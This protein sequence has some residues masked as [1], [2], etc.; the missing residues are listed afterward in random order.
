MEQLQYLI[1]RI[2]KMDE[3]YDEKLDKILYQTTKTN[4]RVTNLED[5]VAGVKN[6]VVG[7]NKIITHLQAVE[8]N[9]KGRDKTL[10]AG[11]AL[12][13]ALLTAIIQHFISKI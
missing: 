9:N 10:L 1:D 8:N 13:G 4:G 11:A 7:I 5:K 6:R 2:D 3:K 12:F